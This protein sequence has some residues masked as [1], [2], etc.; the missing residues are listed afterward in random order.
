MKKALLLLKSIGFMLMMTLFYQSAQAQTITGSK[1]SYD[2]NFNPTLS[3]SINNPTN[4]TI[5][6]AQIVIYTQLKGTRSYDISGSDNQTKTVQ[7]NIPP[8]QTKT[9]Q[10]PFSLK[11]NY[12]YVN[13]A[14]KTVRFSDGSIK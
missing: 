1:V 10:V 14:L 11:N 12:N 4:K 7:I 2:A 9:V 3:V 13:C 6:S 5:T 8:F